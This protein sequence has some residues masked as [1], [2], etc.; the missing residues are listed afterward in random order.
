[1]S[2]AMRAGL[3]RYL[4]DHALGV[5]RSE[6]L[7]AALEAAS[8]LP[9]ATVAGD[10]VRRAGP[11]R[12]ALRWEGRTVHLAQAGDDL[13]TLPVALRIATDAGEVRRTVL[14]EGPTASLT[15]PGEVLWAVADG[16]FRTA[17]PKG[18]P[19]LAALSEAEAIVLAEDAWLALWAAEIDLPAFLALAAEALAAGRAHAPLRAHLADLRDLGIALMQ[20]AARLAPGDPDLLSFLP[21]LNNNRANDAVVAMADA[22]MQ[23]FP[24]RADGPFWKAQVLVQASGETGN[25]ALAEQAAPLLERAL[26]LDP[27]H[28][29]AAVAL[30]NLARVR[31]RD[32]EA[33]NILRRLLATK[34]DH[35][36]SL[37]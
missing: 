11:A 32:D 7:W 22:T 34:P 1:M 25:P 29:D 24:D 2:P 28:A 4:A 8:G 23:R 27:G 12:I 30:A 31:G 9:V 16:Y 21:W 5:A 26:Q 14:L 3:G 17:Y 13:V 18:R 20:E 35:G 37:A 15:L 33:A 6:D 19:P 36:L 10:F